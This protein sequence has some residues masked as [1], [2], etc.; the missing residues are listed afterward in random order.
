MII[1]NNNEVHH[2]KLDIVHI[3]SMFSNY[4]TNKLDHS[5]WCVLGEGVNMG[6]GTNGPSNRRMHGA[7][8]DGKDVSGVHGTSPS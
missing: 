5:H 3:I 2:Q 6:W 1:K 7:H 8:P 4:R